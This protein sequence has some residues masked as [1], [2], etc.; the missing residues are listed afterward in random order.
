MYNWRDD[1]ENRYR[2]RYTDI[3]PVFADNAQTIT[4]FEGIAQR[5]SKGGLGND[6]IKNRRLEDQRV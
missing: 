1:W 5:E 6:R 2:L 3:E 4:G